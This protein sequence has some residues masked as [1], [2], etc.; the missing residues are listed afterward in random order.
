MWVFLKYSSFEDAIYQI[1]YPT[2]FKNSLKLHFR[3]KG[4]FS[5]NEIMFQHEY[6]EIAKNIEPNLTLVLL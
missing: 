5:H 3:T 1:S 2:L 6:L 4:F